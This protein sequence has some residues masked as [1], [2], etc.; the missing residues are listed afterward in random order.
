MP[1]ASLVPSFS[2]LNLRR[3]NN[4]GGILTDAERKTEALTRQV[5]MELEQQLKSGEPHGTCPKCGTKVMPA[6]E[7][8]KALNQIYHATCF[9]CCECNRTLLGKTFY[10]VGDKVYCEE[11]FNV[12]LHQNAISKY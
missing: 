2:N 3:V 4:N 9:V 12:S 1:V 11:D 8:C 10:P 5:E 6:Q 7:A